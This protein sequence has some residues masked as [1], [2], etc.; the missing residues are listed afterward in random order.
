MPPELIAAWESLEASL[1]TIRPGCAAVV[2]PH[3]LALVLAEH[4]KQ[5]EEDGQN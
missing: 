5:G 4:K 2:S 3:A 1:A